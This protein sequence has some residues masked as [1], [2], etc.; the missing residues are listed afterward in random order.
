[1]DKYKCLAAGIKLSNIE[2]IDGALDAIANNLILEYET[3]AIIQ[4]LKLSD[5]FSGLNVWHLSLNSTPNR[6]FS[7]DKMKFLSSF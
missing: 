4:F 3:S 6:E 1:M 2:C 5:L 7:L